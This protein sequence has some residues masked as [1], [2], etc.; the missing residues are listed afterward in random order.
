MDRETLKTFEQAQAGALQDRDPRH[1]PSV[2]MDAIARDQEDGAAMIAHPRGRETAPESFGWTGHRA[3]WIA[4]DETAMALHSCGT[5]DRRLGKAL[6]GRGRR[7]GVGAVA[8]TRTDLQRVRTMFDNRA[9]ASGLSELDATARRETA[10][11]EQAILQGDNRLLEEKY[12]SLQY[13]LDRILELRRQARQQAG[14]GLIH[15]G[16][17]WQTVCLSGVHFR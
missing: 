12:G 8:R 13:G 15:G 16:S 1:D 14:C 4:L 2:Y 7:I 6:R 11:I 9:R 17:T 3:A 5:A 10:R